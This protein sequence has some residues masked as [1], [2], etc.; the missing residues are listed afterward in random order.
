MAS[1]SRHSRAGKSGP[2]QRQLRV[3]EML[4]HAMVEVLARAHLHDP[5]LEAARITVT[6]VTVSPDLKNATVYCTT[7]GGR[8]DD[9]AIAALNRSARFL[10]GELGHRISLR[11]TPTLRFE[12]DTSFDEADRIDAILRSPKVAQDLGADEPDDDHG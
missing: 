7:L 5:E 9:T 1:R 12:R 3:G 10:R 2:S 11:Y 8:S 6:A 4:R